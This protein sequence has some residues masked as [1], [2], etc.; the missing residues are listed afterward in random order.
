M[1]LVFSVPATALGRDLHVATSG[2]DTTGDG[3]ASAPY[4]TIQHAAD[5]A[6]AGD[7]VHVAAGEYREAPRVTVSGA[8]GARIVF[9]SDE[10]WGARVIAET[11]DIAWTI[12]GD[13]ID[14]VGFD[15][16]G[17]GRLGILTRGSYVRTIGNHVHDIPAACSS[18]GGAGIDNGNYD[19]HDDDIIANVVHDIGLRDGTACSNVHGLYHANLRGRIENNIVYR[20]WGYGIHTWHAPVAVVIVNNLVFES[21]ASGIIVGA[22]DAPGGVTADGFLVANNILIHN[23]DWGIL[24]YGRTGPSNRYVNNLVFGNG[25]APSMLL[26]GTEE[27]TVDADPLLVDYQADGSGDYHLTTAS[28]CV[29][30]GTTEGAPDTDHEGTARPMG[31]GIDIGPYE[32]RLGGG[33]AGPTRADGGGPEDD[34][35]PSAGRDAAAR[36]TGGPG[37]IDAGAGTTGAVG[38]CA[39]D[40]AGTRADSGAIPLGVLLLGILGLAVRRPRSLL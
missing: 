40:A 1:V 16:T 20:V 9:V 13:W 4:R 14:I 33:D 37:A 30:R 15:V 34:G 12:D 11:G 5:L 38:D 35:G 28:P 32:L 8:D 36:D 19:A 23:S 22:G 17:R 39:C 18:S 10:P 21:G 7:V 25:I 2:D 6:V 24:E 27:G 3:T 26:T 29:D 31:A